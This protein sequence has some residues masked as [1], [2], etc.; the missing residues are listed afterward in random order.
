MA[1]GQ[2]SFLCHSA[3][4][5]VGKNTKMVQ[6]L[7]LELQIN[8]CEQEKSQIQSLNNEVS[9]FWY[10]CSNGCT[11]L[12][13]SPRACACGLSNMAALGYL[14]LSRGDWLPPAW[15]SEGNMEEAA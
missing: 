5:H 6:V 10:F 4:L 2:L 13:L 9:C 8:F 14:D 3:H 1:I 7:I 12:G 15:A 11:Q